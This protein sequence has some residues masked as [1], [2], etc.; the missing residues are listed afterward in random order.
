ML[1]TCRACMHGQC[2]LIQGGVTLVQFGLV[3]WV[4]GGGGGG[5][6]GGMATILDEYLQKVIVISS[7]KVI[8]ITIGSQ[9]AAYAWKHKGI[10]PFKV[11]G[12]IPTYYRWSGL[13]A[14][15]G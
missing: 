2:R 14:V 6:G 8:V 12:R 15:G 3:W 11:R 10:L 7:R 13:P 4:F 5:G 9:A 1:E